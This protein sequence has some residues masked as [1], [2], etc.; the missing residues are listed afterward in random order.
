MTLSLCRQILKYEKADDHKIKKNLELIG[1][2][3]VNTYKLKI[4]SL[5]GHILHEH[6]INHRYRKI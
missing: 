3:T 5:S 6:Q 1:S 4:C 2:K